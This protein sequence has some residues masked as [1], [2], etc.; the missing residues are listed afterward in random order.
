QYFE[1]YLGLVP[2]QAVPHPEQRV[3]SEVHRKLKL[4]KGELRGLRDEEIAILR[5]PPATYD[6]SWYPVVRIELK[7]DC[8]IRQIDEEVTPVVCMV[9]ALD[10]DAQ[11]TAWS[12]RLAKVELSDQVRKVMKE[13]L[14]ERKASGDLFQATGFMGDRQR[15]REDALDVNDEMPDNLVS[16]NV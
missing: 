14:E 7:P 9:Q 15:W 3:L 16:V 11:M 1:E 8:Q 5:L 10:D 2:T 4:S 6:Q 13:L 12:L